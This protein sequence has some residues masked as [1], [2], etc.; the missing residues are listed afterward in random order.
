MED[1]KDIVVALTSFWFFFNIAKADPNKTFL[2]C[3][4]NSQVS[5]DARHYKDAVVD[6]MV[7]LID[8]TPTVKGFDYYNEAVDHDGMTTYGHGVC[9][10]TLTADECHSCN[11]IAANFL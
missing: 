5:H 9:T 11:D 1:M 8:D 2:Y 6:L 3:F 4:C 10:E 7:G